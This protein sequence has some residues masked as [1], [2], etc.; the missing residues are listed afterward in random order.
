MTTGWESPEVLRA[1]LTDI[2]RR[3]ADRVTSEHLTVRGPE[4]GMTVV[5]G[6]DGFLVAVGIEHSVRRRRTASEVAAI[7][8]AAVRNAELVAADRRREIAETMEAS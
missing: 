4:Q 6:A 5:V 3:F 1:T 2:M 7:V 8:A